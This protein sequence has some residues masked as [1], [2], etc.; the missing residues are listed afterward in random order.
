MHMARGGIPTD[1]YHWANTKISYL[2]CLQKHDVSYTYLVEDRAKFHAN[3]EMC[4]KSCPILQLSYMTEIQ[5][6]IL[7]MWLQANI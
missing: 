5:T 3:E 6:F 1:Q 2:P 7:C 4:R